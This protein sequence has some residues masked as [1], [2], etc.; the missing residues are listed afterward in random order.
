MASWHNQSAL[1]PARVRY[2][3]VKMARPK[4]LRRREAQPRIDALGAKA[5]EETIK[6]A[7]KCEK[8]FM[9]NLREANNLPFDED[10]SILERLEF[11]IH[12]PWI[13]LSGDSLHR[14]SYKRKAQKSIAQ[15]CRK[16]LQ[17]DSS[18]RL[19]RYRLI[20]YVIAYVMCKWTSS[21]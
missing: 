21:H 4:L 7:E 5:L 1:F 10:Y 16:L 18:A 19:S 11:K 12:L 13:G 6:R 8:S 15:R 14:L 2:L 3:V 9:P 17:V 20:A